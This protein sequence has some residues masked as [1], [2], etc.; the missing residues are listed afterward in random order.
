[1]TKS[2]ILEHTHVKTTKK[3]KKSGKFEAETQIGF[4]SV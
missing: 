1:M 3:G 4:K 2:R